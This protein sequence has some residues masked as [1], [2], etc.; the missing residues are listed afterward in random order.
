MSVGVGIRIASED[1]AP[2][3]ARAS[4]YAEK[5]GEPCY[6]LAVVAD[7]SGASLSERERRTMETNLALIARLAAT[8]VVQE[9]DDVPRA[10]VSAARLFGVRTLFVRRGPRRRFRRTV[11]ESIL[12]LEPPFEVVVV[13]PEPDARRQRT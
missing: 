7:L 2:L 10:L 9:A 6:A 13:G 4:E 3:I 11:A 5:Q 8:P 1:A 12:R